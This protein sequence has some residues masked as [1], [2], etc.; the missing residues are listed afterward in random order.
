M[1][2]PY[3]ALADDLLP[4][5]PGRREPRALKRRPKPYPL[6]TC[7]RHH[8]REIPHTGGHWQGEPHPTKTG[9]KSRP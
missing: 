3:Q 7:H 8:Y 1:D 2:D 5:R 6:L 9:R 4:Q